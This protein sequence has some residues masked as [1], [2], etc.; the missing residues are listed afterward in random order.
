V[1]T[2]QYYNER[3]KSLSPVGANWSTLTTIRVL[4][5]LK[6]KKTTPKKDM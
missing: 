4:E 1:L 5:I 2:W 3:D 6:L